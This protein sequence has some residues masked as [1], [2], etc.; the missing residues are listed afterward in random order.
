MCIPVEAHH[1][2]F[3]LAT[4]AAFPGLLLDVSGYARHQCKGNDCLNGG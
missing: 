1:R 4:L 2:K 3:K